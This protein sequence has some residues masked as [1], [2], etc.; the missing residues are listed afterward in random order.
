MERVASTR[1]AAGC[2]AVVV[3]PWPRV[4]GRP[5]FG[6]LAVSLVVCLVAAAGLHAAD[7]PYLPALPPSPPRPAAAKAD[8]PTPAQTPPTEKKPDPKAP[9]DDPLP[10]PRPLPFPG[11]ALPETPQTS[12]PGSTP[13]PSK[14][15]LEQFNQFVEERIDP[16]NTL[17]VVVGRQTLL[18]FKQKPNRVLVA[19]GEIAD[20][21]NPFEVNPNPKELVVTGKK[22]GSTVLDLWFP[23][24]K[25]ATKEVVLSYL[26]RVLPDPDAYGRREESFRR[27]QD[28]IN[29]KFPDSVVRL[30][31]LSNN[32]LLVCGQAKDGFEAQQILSV[33]GVNVAQPPRLPVDQV[34]L[35]VNVAP[36]PGGLEPGG[37]GDFLL[38]SATG[39]RYAVVNLLRVPGEQQVLLHVTVAEINRTAA[40]SIGVN[41]EQIAI[42][43]NAFA[44]TVGNIAG[45]IVNAG[46]TGASGTTPG[47]T[48]NQASAA[49]NL[50]FVI[51]GGRVVAAVDA[52]KNLDFA[53]TLTEPTLTA[54]NGHTAT[55]HVGGQ[56]PIP[57]VTGFTAAGLQGVSFQNFGVSLSFTP[58]IT[59]KDLIRLQMSAEVSTRDLQSAAVV[60]NTT[61]PG[62]NTRNFDTTVE[63]RSGQT[64]AVGGLIQNNFG[65]DASRVPLFG[66]LPVLGRLFAFDRTSA[67]EQ[68]LVVLVT[69]ELVEPLNPGECAPLPGGDVFEPGDVEFYVLGRLESRRPYDFRSSA[70]TDLAREARY[71]HCEQLFIFGPQGH[72]DGKP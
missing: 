55:S 63:L 45:Q 58:Y 65:A 44:S 52:L 30:T 70:M 18:R 47:A 4:G 3:R 35:N 6:R 59:D 39:E 66:E 64:L 22:P 69:P 53:R 15:V 42:G 37:L 1:P 60:G 29:T 26:I 51:D 46:V 68:E 57:V 20:A 8:P 67:G 34:N 43:N 36:G 9:A 10:I 56:F 40:R 49:N 2:R 25:D 17:D 27:L 72:S 62:L 54:L 28:E 23:D 71:R 11:C 12:Y 61:I 14:E 5:E 38:V 33:I 19:D 48:G 32:K 24:P 50:P 21:K 7:S 16:A 41:F 13:R 31:L